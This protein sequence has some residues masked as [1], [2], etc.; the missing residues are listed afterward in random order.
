MAPQLQAGGDEGVDSSLRDSDAAAQGSQ[1][2]V[3]EKPTD[4]AAECTTAPLLLTMAR[5]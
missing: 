4:F 3:T 1:S 2:Q 5:S